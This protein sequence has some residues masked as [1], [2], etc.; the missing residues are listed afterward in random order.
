MRTGRRS[1]RRNGSWTRSR[2]TH[3]TRGWCSTRCTAAA[4]GSPAGSPVVRMLPPEN[5]KVR[6]FV[7]EAV[8][9]SL[10][11]GRTGR[12]PLRRLRRRTS[13][14]R[15]LRL[16]PGR[17]HADRYLQQRHPRQARLHGRGA[18]ATPPMPCKLHP[19]AAG[20][21]HA[22]DEMTRRRGARPSTC[23]ASTSASARST[24]S[25][26]SRCRCSAARSSAFSAPTA[27]AR[28]RRS[29]CCAACSR[30]TAGSGTCLGYDIVRDSR[31]DQA[32][33]RLHDPALL[34]LGR[35]DH[36]REPAISSR[37][38]RHARRAAAPSQTA[39][40][41]ARA[42]ASAQRSS[43][44]RSPAA[45]SSAWRSRPACCTTRNCCCST[46]RPPASIPRRG[47]IS[48]TSC[49]GSPRDG[50]T[51]LVSTH[52][53]DEAER[54]HKLAY[55]VY[56]RLLAQ[57]TAAGGDR[58]RRRC[59]PGR[60][61]GGDLPGTGR[62]RC[63]PARA[64]SRRWPS[65]ARC[66]SAARDARALRRDAR[67]AGARAPDCACEPIRTSLEDVFIHLMSAPA[68]APMHGSAH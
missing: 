48:G 9:G 10:A 52:Y 41:A 26:T 13:R 24:S 42:G 6:F 46:N 55:I 15:Q 67:A 49:T 40:R 43:P 21:G 25:R 57:G 53:M 37:A 45:G 61:T 59:P 31:A 7:P 44:A 38:L 36:P 32:P 20:A 17:I 66:T 28:R 4:S 22:G 27:A 19:G 68:R 5:V 18:A 1:P 60:S 16:G 62:P 8:L 12:D 30:P 47:A 33:G 58:S 23:T 39:A 50:I 35:P 2:C 63:G 34:V 65:A 29:A 3:C 51:V 64:S 56:G 14:H 54:C 11:P